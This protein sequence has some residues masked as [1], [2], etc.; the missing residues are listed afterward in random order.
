MNNKTILITGAS[1]G[2]GL[3]IARRLHD[4]GDRVIGTSRSPEAADAPGIRLLPLD[5]TRPE[6]IRAAV[7]AAIA[8]AGRIDVLIN[9]AG[10]DLYGAVEETSSAELS[11][12]MA[13]N[14]TGAAE[15]MRVVLPHLRAQGGG[16]II[17]ISSIGGRIS[18]PFNSAY[19]ASKFALEG[20]SEALRYEVLRHNIYVS[21]V[22]PGPV[23]TDTLDTSI[24][25]PRVDHP[26]Y[27]G[28][29]QRMIA[30]MIESGRTTSVTPDQV[31]RV[32]ETIIAAPAPRLRYPVGMLARMMPLMKALLPQS[33]FEAFILRQFMS[34]PVAAP[35]LEGSHAG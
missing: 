29:R 33:L 35:R 11:V 15:L 18:L 8:E 14:F 13:T 5:V 27:A 12:Q 3:A 26:L 30:T 6:S 4:R 31:A 24:Q 20:F 22:E 7:D 10:Y 25:S 1:K 9:N 28:A 32:V 17:N 19:A 23:R 34:D 16:R 2:I 21:L